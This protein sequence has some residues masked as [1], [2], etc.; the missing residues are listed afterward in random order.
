MHTVIESIHFDIDNKL[1]LLIMEKT[2]DFSKIF[3]D[4]ES[5][6]VILEQKS[7]DKDK[8]DVVEIS[9][10][11]PQARL[12]AKHQAH[13]FELALEAAVNEM[14]KQLKKHKEKKTMFDGY[15]AGA[16]ESL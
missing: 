6:K 12:F 2:S 7:D 11:V 9:L 5:C 3:E 10:N 15:P 14:K 8:N 1:K 16:K 4:A 13:T